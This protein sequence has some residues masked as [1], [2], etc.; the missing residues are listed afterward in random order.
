MDVL[1]SAGDWDERY[2]ASGLVW[3]VDPNMWVRQHT[4]H[5]SP[6]TA[7]DLA[8]GEGRNAIW[9]A[10]RGWDVTA[11][12]FSAVATQKGREQALQHGDDTAGRIRWVTD[13]VLH[14]T[15]P[16][17]YD[18][19][20]VI[21]LQLP[22]DQRRTALRR[23]ASAVATGGRLLVVAHHTDNLT[24]GVGG[25]QNAEFLYTEAD[26]LADLA[27]LPHLTPRTAERVERPVE[28]RPRPALDLVVDMERLKPE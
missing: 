2:R 9:L 16:A 15:P 3:S 28:G 4:E 21:Y 18:L 17:T 10:A 8:S 13:D 7:L 12:D 24:Q 20:L 27:D 11:V 25:P 14:Y 23:A 5:L 1:Q 6:G 19:V 26:V 22:A